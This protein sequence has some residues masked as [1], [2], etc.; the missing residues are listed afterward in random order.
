MT[1]YANAYTEVYGI[2]EQLSEEDFNKI[3][4]QVVET[5]RENQNSEYDFELD[6][7]LELKDQKLL[8]ETK[9]ILFNLFRDYLSEPW[10]KEKIIKMQ[11]EERYKNEL[12][13]HKKYENF[14]VFQNNIAKCEKERNIT[15]EFIEKLQAL[16]GIGIDVSKII[17]TD[18]IFSL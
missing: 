18:T 9:A 4:P 15:N 10:Q 3:P 1:R 2:L 6:E 7:E 17:K 8:P 11:A 12:E 16:Q 14:N 5:I 13:K